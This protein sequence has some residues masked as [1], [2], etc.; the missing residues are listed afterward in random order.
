[1]KDGQK[2]NE[3]KSVIDHTEEQK[4]EMIEIGER[5]RSIRLTAGKEGRGLTQNEFAEKINAER[6]TVG[7]WERGITPISLPYLLRICRANWC[8]TRDS[9]K[10]G[11][12]S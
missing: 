3:E 8:R 5:I 4:K 2:K 6:E 10:M 7:K 1:M 11:K 9:R 12:R